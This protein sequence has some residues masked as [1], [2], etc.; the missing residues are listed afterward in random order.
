MIEITILPP[1]RWK[2]AR[3]L[4]LQGLKSAPLAFTSSYEEEVNLADVEWQR[5]MKN[6]LVALSDNK[7]V[8][9]LTYRFGEKMKSKHVAHLLGFYVSPE[10]SGRGVGKRLL[11]M[12]FELIQVNKNIV[13]I[14]LIVN[15]KQVTAVRL[16]KS[17][18]FT[19]VGQMQ[20]EIKVDEEF[21]DELIME[22]LL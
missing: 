10:F 7:P 18:G 3:E 19:V 15:P 12:V 16:Y 1:E 5:R 9:T 4:R 6:M 22:K 21:Y 14:Q 2:E 8:G 17:M 11:E 13:K 20:K